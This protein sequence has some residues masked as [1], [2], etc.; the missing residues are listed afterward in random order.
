MRRRSVAALWALVLAVTARG[1]RA[2]EAEPEFDA[3]LEDKDKVLQTEMEQATPGDRRGFSVV[4]DDDI[5]ALEVGD[6]YKSNGSFFK[7]TAIGS[8]GTAGGRFSA[9]RTAGRFD[10][11][12][13][14]GRVS[15]LG[16][17]TIV[18]RETLLSLYLSGGWVMHAIS[19]V[20]LLAIVLTLNSIWEYRR[21]KQCPPRFVDE[22]RRAISKGD[23]GQFEDLALREKGFFAA[24]CQAMAMDFKTSTVEDIK[25]RCESRASQQITLLRM[26][27]KALNLAAVLSPLMGLLGTVIGLVMCFESLQYE[28]ASAAKSQLLAA[29]VRVALFT[30]VYGLLVAIPSLAVFFLFNQKLNAIAA[31]CEGVATEFVQQLAALKRVAGGPAAAPAAAQAA[32][33]PAPATEEQ[34]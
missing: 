13:S 31:Y 22:A 20:L 23:L 26:P 10:P 24:I 33:A 15:G 14:W 5:A 30:T 32:D 17:L 28:A 4:T 18:T 7:V 25:T 3:V 9:E 21:K 29:G 34:P 11:G 16:P 6:I 19:F 1:A 27:L 12:R 8:K 2:G